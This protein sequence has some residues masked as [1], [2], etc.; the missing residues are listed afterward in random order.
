[1]RG[2][3]VVGREEYFLSQLAGDIVILHLDGS[4]SEVEPASHRAGSCAVT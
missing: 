3:S 4:T 1:M 2:E